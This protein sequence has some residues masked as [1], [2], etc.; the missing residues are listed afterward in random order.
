L[1]IIVIVRNPKLLINNKT[2][3]NNRQFGGIGQ[4][5]STQTGK[6]A[7][8]IGPRSPGLATGE[9]LREG[10]GQLARAGLPP[11]GSGKKCLLITHSH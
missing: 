8:V 7:Q 6:L 3:Q 1:D 10:L 11:V 5:L 2:G 9:G 4:L